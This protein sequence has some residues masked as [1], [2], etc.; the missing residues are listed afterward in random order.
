MLRRQLGLLEF[1]PC[2][3]VGSGFKVTEEA[4]SLHKQMYH[5]PLCLCP[6]IHCLQKYQAKPCPLGPK[7]QAC[8]FGCRTKKREHSP[9]QQLSGRL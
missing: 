3:T 5:S 9:K 4:P 2:P 6:Q 7:V 8:I 1:E